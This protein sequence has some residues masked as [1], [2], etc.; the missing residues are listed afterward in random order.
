MDTDKTRFGFLGSLCSYFGLSVRS[1]GVADLCF[2]WRRRPKGIVLRRNFSSHRRY[3]V[4]ELRS[5]SENSIYPV[6]GVQRGETAKL[7]IDGA[8]KRGGWSPKKVVSAGRREV[9]GRAP[10]TSQRI[11]EQSEGV[12]RTAGRGLLRCRHAHLAGLHCSRVPARGLSET[13]CHNR[14]A[15]VGRSV[16]RDRVLSGRPRSDRCLSG[17]AG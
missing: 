10:R 1:C 3:Q 11:E 13:I 9:N 12:H 4:L 5:H 17:S 2:Q 14:A 16:R 7:L 15:S 8:K 6:G